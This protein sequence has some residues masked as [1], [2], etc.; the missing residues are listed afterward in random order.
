MVGKVGSTPETQGAEKSKENRKKLTADFGGAGKISSSE[1]KQF[2][3]LKKK[4]E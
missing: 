2:G 4:K 1:T 3:G